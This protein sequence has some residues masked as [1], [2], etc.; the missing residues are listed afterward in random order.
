M[1]FECEA[2]CSNCIVY[3]RA[4]P[5]RQ[6]SSSLSPLGVPNYPW[7]IVGM[8][9]VTDLPKSSKFNFSAILILVCQ[10]TKMAYFVPCHNKEISLNEIADLFIDNC[11]KLHGVPK[12]IV[13]DRDPQFLGNFFQSFTR[14]LNTNLSMSKARHPQT[15]SL[16]ERVN[17]TLQILL[18]CYTAESR[19]D[20][21]FYVPMVTFYYNCSI[22]EA[23]KHSPFEVSYG[24]QPT[25]IFDRLLPLTGAPTLVADRLTKLA[26]VRDDVRELPTLSKH[27]MVARSSRPAPIFFVGDFAFLSSKG[28]H[29]HS[30][31][32]NI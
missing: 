5:S 11:Y 6:G 2:H 9:F 30:Q 12:V 24:F 17:E 20:W 15:D 28:L 26:S 23:S 22:N 13:S 21:V 25:T 3:D 10:L 19:F 1:S 14:K 8:D 16:T 31:N 27:R 29:I 18:R 32:A 7:E 4:K